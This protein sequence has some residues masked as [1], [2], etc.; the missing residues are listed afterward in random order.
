MKLDDFL[1][2]KKVR[3]VKGV[4]EYNKGNEY[5]FS[6]GIEVTD[7]YGN[8]V[9][10]KLDEFIRYF[11]PVIDDMSK[12]DDEID[13]TQNSV[14]ASDIQATNEL[15]NQPMGT[16]TVSEPKFKVGDKVYLPVL[17]N[18]CTIDKAGKVI[19]SDGDYFCDISDDHTFGFCH[20]TQENYELLCKLY[21]HIEFEQPPKE[22]KGSDLCRAMLEKGWKYVL[23]YVSAESDKQA[24]ETKSEPTPIYGVKHSRFLC[25][26][27]SSVSFAVPFDPRTG[28][29]L[30]EAALTGGNDD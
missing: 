10:F 6:I 1:E 13:T 17:E 19:T 12:S 4:D 7:N 14:E 11:E 29:P 3:C 22:L 5:R 23:C 16:R 15:D 9:F 26:Y 25:G 30:T 21:P 2:C 8:D 27:D 24:V 20:A 28:E 18:V